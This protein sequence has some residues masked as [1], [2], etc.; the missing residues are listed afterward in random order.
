MS[1]AA[2]EPLASRRS[3]KFRLLQRSSGLADNASQ[4]TVRI[5][6]VG[7]KVRRE[8]R[9]FLRNE[10]APFVTILEP[11]S[12]SEVRCFVREFAEAI[13]N[14][15]CNLVV[16]CDR[17]K[18]QQQPKLI[19]TLLLAIDRHDLYGRFAILKTSRGDGQLE[20]L[21]RLTDASSGLCLEGVEL[22]TVGAEECP[23]VKSQ[24]REWASAQVVD[25]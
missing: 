16:A 7:L 22:S 1:R 2:S 21:R 17:A 18:L 25:G 11:A 12:H 15:D 4:E 23:Y 10:K 6:L 3:R 19:R 9:R 13:A 14:L 5:S 20:E 24:I 8:L